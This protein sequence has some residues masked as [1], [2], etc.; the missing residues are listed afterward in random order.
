MYRDGTTADSCNAFDDRRLEC[1]LKSAFAD[2]VLVGAGTSARHKIDCPRPCG[3]E[4]A[5]LISRKLKNVCSLGSF[6]STGKGEVL[7]DVLRGGEAKSSN[8][9]LISDVVNIDEKSS[10]IFCRSL[11]LERCSEPSSEIGLVGG[12]SSEATREQEDGED[13]FH[14]CLFSNRRVN[15]KVRTPFHF[16][17]AC[18]KDRSNLWR[19][20]GHLASFSFPTA[21]L[22]GAGAS[23]EL[24]TRLRQ[25]GGRRALV[26]TDKALA[27]THAFEV[28]ANHLGRANLGKTWELFDGVHSNPS[29]QDVV[30]AAKTFRE[31]KCDTVVAF[32]GGS[33]ID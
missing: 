23:S 21:I 31:T 3:V 28:L 30:D 6:P 25:M 18:K 29:E 12:A 2:V 15:V 1:S 27:Q 32:G 4:S 19:M 9:T 26:V 8:A 7:I 14:R 20:G 13:A 22:F 17:S 10:C 16:F 11:G 24:P 33:A 5:N